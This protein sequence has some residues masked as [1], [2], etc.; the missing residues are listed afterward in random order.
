MEALMKYKTLQV[1]SI[2]LSLSTVNIDALAA[3]YI[4]ETSTTSFGDQIVP[5]LG[6]CDLAYDTSVLSNS[7]G[8]ICSAATGSRG[9]YKVYAA[10]NTTVRIVVKPHNNSGDGVVF[11]PEGVIFSDSTPAISYLDNNTTNIDSGTSGIVEIYVGGNLTLVSKPSVSTSYNFT[12]EIDFS[13][14]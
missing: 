10:P 7:S 1:L 2:M 3:P 9:H 14:I 4:V 13:E 8:A 6:A 12:Y 11:F 5:S